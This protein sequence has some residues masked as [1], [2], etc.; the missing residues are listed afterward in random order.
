MVSLHKAEWGYITSNNC[1]FTGL[2]SKIEYMYGKIE[3][4]NGRP[5]QG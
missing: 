5:V 2:N 3:C 4:V 1:I